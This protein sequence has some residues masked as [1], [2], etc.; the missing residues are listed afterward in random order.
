[1]QFTIEKEVFLKALAKIQSVVEKR[2]TIPIL[3]NV[4]ITTEEDGICLTAT[5]LEVGIRT[6]YPANIQKGGRITVAAKKLFEIIK[7]LPDSTV[8]FAAKENC[9]IEIKCG[10]S[11]FNVVGLSPDEFPPFPSTS[12]DK[13]IT[14]ESSV[15][16]EMIEKT[17][18]SISTD[19]TKYNLNGIYFQRESTDTDTRLMMVATDGHRLALVRKSLAVPAIEELEKGVILPRKGITE[20]RKV[21]DEGEGAIQLGFTE[22]NAVIMRD[23]TVVVM[24]LV[25][26]DFPDYNRVIPPQQSAGAMITR[27]LFLHALRRTAVLS[28]EKSKGIKLGFA[29]GRLE[30]TSSQAEVGDAREELEIDYAGEEMTIGFNARY[31]IDILQAMDT[32]Q[33]ELVLKDNI[34]PG[35]IRVRDEDGFLAVVMPMRL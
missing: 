13:S 27:D 11:V 23:K 22:N 25:D 35:L 28:N 18:F 19:E 24:R 26:G 29:A 12:Q 32:E 4:L 10:K 9:W 2:H 30:L 15:L 6:H 8:S 16:R 31:L 5:D 3:S 34:S 14:I 20:L 7:E 21:T 1:M 17:A 33:I